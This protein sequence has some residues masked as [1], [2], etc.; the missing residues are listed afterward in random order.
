MEPEGALGGRDALPGLQGHAVL[1]ALPDHAVV[2]RAEPG[3]SRGHAGSVRVRQVPPQRLGRHRPSCWPGRRRHGRSRA[4]SRSRCTPASR[5]V[6]VAQGDES[7]I[8]AK[9]RLV[10]LDGDYEILDEMDGADLVDLTY[11]PLFTDMLPE[12]LAFVVLDA[13]GAGE[14]GRGHRNRPHRRGVRRRRPRALPAHGRRDPPRGRARRTVPRRSDAIPRACSSRTPIRRSSRTCAS[15]AASTAPSGSCTRI[16]SAGAATRRCS[17]TRSRPGSSAPPPSRIACSLTTAACTGSRRTSATVGW[18]TGSRASS[19]GTCRAAGTGARRCPSG[20]ARTCDEKF[21]AG[22]AADVGL[23]VDD[24]LHRPFID[25]VTLPCTACGGV[26]RRVPDVIDAW[27]DS[28]AMPF[29]QK[30]YPFEN[31]ELFERTHP[32][33]FICEGVDQ[34]RGWFFSLLAESTLLF[35][36]PAYR[37][38]VVVGTL[39]DKHGKKMSKS[40]RQHH[41]AEHHLRPVRRRRRALVLLRA[42]RR[43]RRAAREPHVIPGRRAPLHADALERL[44]VLRHLRAHRRVRSGLGRSRGDRAP[45]RSTAGV[46]PRLAET[47]EAV[48]EAMERYDA[49]D[50]VHA[51]EAFVEDLSKWYV[52][53]SRRRFWKSAGSSDDSLVG[54]RDPAHRA[55]DAGGAGRAV[56]AL[57]GRAYVPQPQRLQRRSAVRPGRPRLR[58]TSPTIRRWRARGVTRT[59]S[60]R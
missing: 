47:V 14:H 33:D 30:H 19:T 42:G 1:P 32:A 53:R 38:C 29:A 25:E 46:S 4:T 58:C 41:R 34:T 16:R 51:V 11:E 17:T 59:S 48:R 20:C 31:R 35:D 49:S 6:R 40:R 9:Q 50:A 45:G 8:L 39:Q 2:A 28:G 24:D 21:C 13:P 12:G 57:H 3:I 18:A 44:L 36:L 22:S 23:T 60:S 56:H 7:Y 52:R 27:Y 37:N 15:R 55:A 43:E 5:Y 10:V 26:M 54:V